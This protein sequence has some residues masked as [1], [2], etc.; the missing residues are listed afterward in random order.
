M[1]RQN[2]CDNCCNGCYNN[3]PWCCPEN[4]PICGNPCIVCPE[5]RQG[6]P[7]V[8]GPV[9]PAGPQGIQ[10]EVGPAGPQGI[11][12]EVGPVGPAGPQGIQG[13]V[14][15]VGPAGP[16][17]IQGE[18]GPVGPA[19]PQGIQGEVGPV[20]PAGPQGIQ[21]EVGPAGPQGIQG[22]VGP[23]G[24]QGIQG[25]VG[26]AGP[27]GIQGE[28]GPAGGVLS[29]AD[30]YALMPPD[31]AATVAAG[32]DVSFP[33]DGP[34]SGTDITRL[35]ADSFQ[36]GP[37]GTY[38]VFFEVSV[39]E[40]GQLI[41]TLNGADL[42]YTVVGRATGASQIV[43]MALVETTTEN[44]VLTVRNPEGTAEALTI[45]PLAG[46]VRPVSAHLVIV[47]IQ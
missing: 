2:C 44:S 14:G 42:P 41:L 16:Q 45:T 38:Q 3:N 24:P 12:G 30:F 37:I 9:G 40:A 33:Q 32:T 1:N 13:E 27:Q 7:G 18:V 10:G 22:E 21:G 6:P 47:Q 26:P 35:G 19:G 8:R 4:Q 20:G 34:N 23:A 11:Q 29:F 5:G 17:G 25:E 46:G 43:G 28:Q 31:N 39:T 36:L 15:P